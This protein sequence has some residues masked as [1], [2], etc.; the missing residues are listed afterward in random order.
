MLE[1]FLLMWKSFYFL[2]LELG[3]IWDG[4]NPGVPRPVSAS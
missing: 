1:P 4:G 2:E 3:R